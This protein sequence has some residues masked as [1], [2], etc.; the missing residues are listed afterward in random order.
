[1]EAG[2]RGPASSRRG[3]PRR[4][5][6]FSRLSPRLGPQERLAGA[7]EGHLL[8]GASTTSTRL[9]PTARLDIK[10]SE[11]ASGMLA[12]P[13]RSGRDAA[14]GGR[15]SGS[16]LRSKFSVSES[17]LCAPRRGL[18]VAA[19]DRKKTRRGRTATLRH[20]RAPRGGSGTPA[21]PTRDHGGGLSGVDG[22]DRAP[23]RALRN[24]R[25]GKGV[26]KP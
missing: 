13:A 8:L 26:L 11:M 12:M 15:A 23:G 24:P 5:G 16:K 7:A 6:R 10:T 20:R 22:S 17:F 14:A 2:Q 25:H 3:L 18:E 1:M 21:G 4:R 19:Q 9:T